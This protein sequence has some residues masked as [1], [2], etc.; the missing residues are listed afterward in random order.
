[1]TGQKFRKLTVIS[2]ADTPSS[3]RLMWNCVCECGTFIVVAGTALRAGKSSQCT[4]CGRASA[5]IKKSY[6][7]IHDLLPYINKTNDCWE[8]GGALNSKGYAICGYQGRQWRVSRLVYTLTKGPI[9]ES[10]F[11]CHKCDNP[12]CVNPDHIFIGTQLDN[13]TDMKRKGRGN[14]VGR[15]NPAK[16]PITGRFV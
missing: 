13:I 3:G 9:K 8:W 14:Y 10:L 11:A 7:G 5:A 16:D 15:K 12:R 6:S 1:M 4:K 2:K